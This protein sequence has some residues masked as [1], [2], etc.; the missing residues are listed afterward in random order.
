MATYLLCHRHGPAECRVAFA[1]WKG[2]ESPLRAQGVLSSC[3]NGHHAL[4]WTVK[5]A[6][7]E[8]AL[9]LL[10]PYVARRTDAV[11]VANVPIP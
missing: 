8:A 11:E 2:F 9:A 5:A 1:A 10:P 7:A 3:R 6:H 4:W